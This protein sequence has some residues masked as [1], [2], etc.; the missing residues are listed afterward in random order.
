MSDATSKQEGGDHYRS[1]KI[2]PV[3]FIHANNIPFIEGAVIKYVVRHRSKN[4]AQDI[5]KAIHFLELLLQ[6][7]YPEKQ[8]PAPTATNFPS[9]KLLDEL[10]RER[11][12]RANYGGSQS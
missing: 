4:K 5:R 9:R 12:L 7:E 11:I 2:Q 6:L 3:E 8:E 10:E 1:M